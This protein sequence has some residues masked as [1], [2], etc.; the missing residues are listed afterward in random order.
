MLGESGH[1]QGLVGRLGQAHQD[2]VLVH[3]DAASGLELTVETGRDGGG[4]RQEGP[5]GIHL[6]L[7]ES[8]EALLLQGIVL[9]AGQGGLLATTAHQPT[10]VLGRPRGPGR[11]L[12]VGGFNDPN[13]EYI[14]AGFSANGEIILS[15]Q[16]NAL[17]LDKSLILLCILA[18]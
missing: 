13:N 1:A 14:R 12:G 11:L 10:T 2:L 18:L 7:I 17:L 5:P 9:S 8:T 4:G 16:K 3:G 15:S 6:D